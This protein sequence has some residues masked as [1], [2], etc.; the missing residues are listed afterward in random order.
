MKPSEVKWCPQHGYPLPCPKCGMPLTGPQQK[1]IYEAGRQ[2]AIKEIFE[3]GS[4]ICNEHY[5]K[6][7][8]RGGQV[9]RCCYECWQ[10][11]KEVKNE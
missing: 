8:K 11:L 7:L 9:R 2:S 5:D 1:E 4:E 3:W 6:I 10:S